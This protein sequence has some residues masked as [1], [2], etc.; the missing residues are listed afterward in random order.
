MLQGYV[1]KMRVEFTVPVTY[2]LPM[3]D[4][5]VP[6]N[7]LIGAQIRIEHDGRKQ[8][9]YC[10]RKIKKTY[11]QG[12]C[13]PCMRKLARCDG[14]IVRPENCHYH[15]GTCREPE[16]GEAHCLQPHVVYLANSSGVKVGITRKANLPSR[17]IDQGATQALPIIA[18]SERLLS[19]LVEVAAKDHL[20]DRTN[21]RAMLKGDAE[22]ADLLA[23]KAEL[24]Q[25]VTDR[26]EGIKAEYGEDAVQWLDQTEMQRFQ[27]PVQQYPS[28][29]KSI[30]LDRTHSIN[31]TLNGIKG[32]YLL[33]DDGALNIRRIAGY[34]L[35]IHHT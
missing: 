8:C 13:F 14:C 34:H 9:I 6:L 7:P 23:V 27:Y 3:D 4:E 29:V 11:Q 1:R 5:L 18:V 10:G 2:R 24:K 15:Q 28:S 22:E 31:A 21:W 20:A 26:V 19:G 17:W 33:L 16:W 30:N 32:Q 25:Q 12:Y 35:E